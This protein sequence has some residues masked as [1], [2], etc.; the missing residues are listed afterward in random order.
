[1]GHF[2]TAMSNKPAYTL[3]NQIELLKDRGML[4]RNEITASHCLSTISYYRLKGYWWDMQEDYTLHNLKPN[5][6]FEDIVD[7]Y[8]FDCFDDCIC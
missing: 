3:S 5:T 6:Y 4:F 1:M 7:R 8:N 2:F